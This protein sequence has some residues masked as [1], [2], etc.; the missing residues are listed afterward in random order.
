V[1]RGC[2]IHC[3]P[4]KYS[5]IW[6][7]KN[8][9]IC[10]KSVFY[11]K[12]YNT[13]MIHIKDLFDG[14]KIKPFKEWMPDLTLVDYMKWR[15][16]VDAVLAY[17]VLSIESIDTSQE[18]FEE[19]IRQNM[20]T[21]HIHNKLIVNKTGEL[22]SSK[23]FRYGVVAE[24]WKKV[25]CLAFD[26]VMDTHT[27][28]FQYHI[29]SDR[30][31]TN[32][33]LNKWKIKENKCTFC[34]QENKDILHLFCECEII[35]NEFFQMKEWWKVFYDTYIMKDISCILI[36]NEKGMHLEILL[37]LEFKKYV[38]SC[39]CKESMLTLKGIIVS[40]RLWYQIKRK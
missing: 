11:E 18:N 23:I 27:H 25:F 16:L 20:D 24:Y 32:F 26:T 13:G 1:F 33:W 9:R 31:V 19:P 2:P 7:N 37:T 12:F 10:G 22:I 34:G 30:L 28:I 36:R 21:K 39:R 14:N 8:I 17:K 29:I 38:Y 5:G 15:G 6:Y 4:Q 35:K 40:L 3:I